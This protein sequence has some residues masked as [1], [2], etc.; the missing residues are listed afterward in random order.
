[1]GQT[2]FFSL[3]FGFLVVAIKGQIST[4]QRVVVTEDTEVNDS[5]TVTT[6][7]LTESQTGGRTLDVPTGVTNS[8]I[9]S[10]TTEPEESDSVT[11]T[12]QNQ[13]K[14]FANTKVVE[15]TAATTSTSNTNSTMDTST[16]TNN[17]N[18]NKSNPNATSNSRVNSLDLS[19]VSA[20]ILDINDSAKEAV[21]TTVDVGV[22]TTTTTASTA[23]T[24]TTTTTTAAVTTK[25]ASNGE[26]VVSTRLPTNELV[27]RPTGFS[28][29]RIQTALP[30]PPI[31][32]EPNKD[33]FMCYHG[34]CT[35]YQCHKAVKIYSMFHKVPCVGR[36]CQIE[37]LQR[38]DSFFIKFQCLNNSKECPCLSKVPNLQKMCCKTSLC[39][40]HTLMCLASS[41]SSSATFVWKNPNLIRSLLL[42]FSFYQQH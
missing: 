42:L 34:N 27:Q 19:S 16:D 38:E 28:V 35:D 33:Q 6:Q 41:S 29:T 10:S 32:V 36:K 9:D 13:S 4:P 23:T 17:N 14:A 40:N 8:D 5:A 22:T 26:I 20:T 31:G 21:F 30:T 15:S 2:M 39:N 1:M 18:N 12:Q 37:I 24:T 3:C 11:G 25:I 7:T